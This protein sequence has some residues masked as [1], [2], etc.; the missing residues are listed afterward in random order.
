MYYSFVNAKLELIFKNST[1]LF[2]FLLFCV[3]FVS[4]CVCILFCCCFVCL[5]VW[6]VGWFLLKD[7]L[8][9]HSCGNLS[10]GN[11]SLKKSS[12]GS[13]KTTLKQMVVIFF[14]FVN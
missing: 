1:H 9:S 8:Q 14:F 10:S 6:L 12:A 4:V 2:S 13:P 5:F 7:V 3:C 11:V